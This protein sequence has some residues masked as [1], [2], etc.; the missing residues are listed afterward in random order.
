[1]GERNN[2]REARGRTAN[3]GSNPASTSKRRRA[4]RPLVPGPRSLSQRHIFYRDLK[5]RYPVI[6]RADGVYLYDHDGRKILDGAAG[7]AVVCLG[8]NHP[9]VVA[10]LE[11]QARKV[12]FA[13]TGSFTSEPAIQLSNEL[14]A[15]APDSLQRV[16]FSSGG[17]ESV[18]AALKLARAYHLEK[19]NDERY[20]VISRFISYH[21][22]TLG[23]LSMTGHHMRRRKYLPLLSSFPRVSPSYCYRCPFDLTPDR[24]DLECAWDLERELVREGPETISAFI[25]EPI[26][27]A[28]APGVGAPQNYYRIIREICDK[29]DILLIADEV[30]TGVGRTGRFFAMQHFGIDPDISVISKGLASGYSPFGAVLVTEKI[31]RTL[32]NSPAHSF[33]HGH[34]YA[35]NP[36][37]CAVGLE[38]LR[39][40]REDNLIEKNER[41]GA[42]LM[43][44]LQVL[45]ER[46]SVGD[47]RGRGMLCGVEFVAERATKKP[48]PAEARFNKRVFE[49]ALNRGV[50]LY[51]G[52]GSVD[53]VGG[54]HMLISP[55]YT[56]SREEIDFLVDTLAE[57]IETAERAVI[58]KGWM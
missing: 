55:P 13:H 53:G 43:E 32:R 54:D 58:R 44:R 23:A 56:I 29:Y 6:S 21:G 38:V 20:R 7:A 37:S 41:D 34:T 12:A 42:Y 52:S 31:Y 46:P 36:L 3:G 50:Y 45:R 30:M 18:E 10:A 35:G 19:G 40:I 15:W 9:R 51:P 39:V 26:I 24:C 49:A 48:F 11:D 33:I 1:M 17:S 25:M 22:A 27:G 4:A 47:I 28:S 57:S 8:H 16:Y 2:G 14:C 5:R